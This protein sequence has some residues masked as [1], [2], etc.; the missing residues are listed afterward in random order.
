MSL[1]TVLH[2]ILRA[3][4]EFSRVLPRRAAAVRGTVPRVLKDAVIVGVA[5]VMIALCAAPPAFNAWRASQVA[6]QTRGLVSAA[7]GAVGMSEAVRA[8]EALQRATVQYQAFGDDN[9]AKEFRDAQ[10]QAEEAVNA[11]LENARSEAVRG[12]YVNLTDALVSLKGEFEQLTTFERDRRR[13]RDALGHA[14]EKM[15]DIATRLFDA[16]RAT[17]NEALSNHAVSFARAAFSA[18]A[19]ARALLDSEDPS[20]SKDFHTN[21]ETAAAA[22]T[23]MGRPEQLS[24]VLASAKTTMGTVRTSY[25]ALTHAL[26][27][28]DLL[29]RDRMVPQFMVM[30]AQLAQE[31]QTIVGELQVA[32]QETLGAMGGQMAWWSA[33]VAF[34]PFIALMWALLLRHGNGGPRFRFWMTSLPRA[35]R[36]E[37]DASLLGTSTVTVRASTMPTG[38]YWRSLAAVFKAGAA[39]MVPHQKKA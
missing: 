26:R 21:L 1:Y 10:S 24:T 39:A 22:L 38:G 16:A 18:R 15:T 13:S 31:R 27:G 36:I 11:G 20:L 7:A 9:A 32:K 28:S 5:G 6:E 37:R 33:P 12:I 23:A 4:R 3:F 19:G 17:Q 30:K 25:G 2:R 8:I 29:Y 35:R 14:A 34:G